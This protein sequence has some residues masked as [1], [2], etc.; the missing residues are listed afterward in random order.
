MT[1]RLSKVFGWHRGIRGSAVLL[2]SCL[3]LWEASAV[4]E[5]PNE[6]FHLPLPTVSSTVISNTPVLQIAETSGLVSPVC[7]PTNRLGPTAPV[8]PGSKESAGE[9]Q[10][11]RK[12]LEQARHWLQ[13]FQPREAETVLVALLGEGSPESIKQ[14]ALLELACAAK[15]EGDLTRAIQIYAQYL[16]RWSNDPLVPEVLLRQGQLF[17]QLGLNNLALAKFYAVMTS[18]LVLKND[19]LAYYQHLVLVAQTEIAETHYQLGK[20]AEA[21]DYFSRLLQQTN[22]ALNRPRT[23][24]RLVRSL[25]AQQRYDEVVARAGDLIARYPDAPEIPEARFY[26]AVAFTKLNRYSE[27]QEQVLNLLRQERQRADT[28]PELWCYWQQRA[29]NEIA[30]QLYAGGD[31]ARA[32]DIYLVLVQLDPKPA[33]RFPVAYQ[34]GL[35][36]EHLG[37]PEKARQNYLDIVG[38]ESE[39]GTNSSPGLKAIVEMSKWR[40]EWVKWQAQAELN[41]KRVAAVTS[42]DASAQ[43]PSSK[44]ENP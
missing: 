30:N 9:A 40:A 42:P 11:F 25:S 23:Q 24:S 43:I 15:T 18:S 8:E 2:L 14:Q 31:F 3:I 28:H 35:T 29:G 17:R 26:L 4:A 36:Y 44:P 32:L 27:A 19:M 41:A 22:G 5:S 34:I 6:P 33:W 1:P 21:S 7:T 12:Q 39:L 37:Q 10:E 13:T 38:R 20:H 16:S